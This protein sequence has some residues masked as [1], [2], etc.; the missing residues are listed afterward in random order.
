VNY[1]TTLRSIL[2][3]DPDQMGINGRMGGPL[4]QGAPAMPPMAGAPMPQPQGG[5]FF[6]EG[7]MGRTLAG[8][9]GDTLLQQTG[10]APVYAPAMQQRRQAEQADARWTRDRA[11]NRED[12]QWE[13]QNKPKDPPSPIYREDNSGNTIAIDPTTGQS[14]VLHQETTPRM[15]FIPDGMGGGRWVPVPTGGAMQ[16]VAPPARPVG[17]LTPLDGGPAPQAPG[18]FRP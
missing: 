11:A 1:G 13:W 15:N 5:G 16:P 8:I 4:P 3:V 14:R 6:R 2:G 17:N 9:I 12:M 18:T 7:G 10:N